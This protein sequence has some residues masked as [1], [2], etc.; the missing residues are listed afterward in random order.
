LWEEKWTRSPPDL[1]NSGFDELDEEPTEDTEDTDFKI[2]IEAPADGGVVS[3]VSVVRGWAIASSGIATV[4]MFVN[5][6]HHSD[7]PIGGK[8]IDI[9]DAY[10]AVTDS[11]RS[12]FSSPAFNF[13]SL[14]AGEHTISIRATSSNGYQLIEETAFRVEP[15]SIETIQEGEYPSLEA[16]SVAVSGEQELTVSGIELQ[17]GRL[18]NARLEWSPAVQGFEIA[19]VTSIEGEL[20][21]FPELEANNSESTANSFTTPA[22]LSGQLS[23]VDDVDWYSVTTNKANQKLEISFYTDSQDGDGQWLVKW[24]GPSCKTHMNISLSQRIFRSADGISSYLIDAC[25]PG[26]YAVGIG[27]YREFYF[28]DDNYNVEVTAYEK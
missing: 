12:G 25:D 9:K 17:G 28:D 2:A 1:C 7:I 10:P 15:L 11:L 16:A 5:G 8:R 20:Q 26:T 23:D 4:E 14:G 6:R 22:R 24:V 18:R 21:V 27:A 3:G 13:N 19:S